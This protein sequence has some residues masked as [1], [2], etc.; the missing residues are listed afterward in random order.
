MEQIPLEIIKEK[1]KDRYETQG[2]ADALFRNDFNLL[3]RLG[4]HPQVATTED[5]QRLVMTVKAASTKGTYAARVR[6]IFKSLRK[7][8]LID[9]MADLDLPNVRKGRGLPHPLTPGEAELV[10]TKIS[11]LCNLIS[12]QP[13]KEFIIQKSN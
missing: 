3:V 8:G 6:S 10:M 11:M 13:N 2:F 9:N 4:V 1:L 12:N 5:L 7:M